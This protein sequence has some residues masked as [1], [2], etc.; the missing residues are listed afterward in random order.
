[1]LYVT[2][3]VPWPATTGGRVRTTQLLSRL[4]KHAKVRMVAITSAPGDGS[5]LNNPGHP[6]LEIRSFTNC[7]APGLINARYS[8]HA[9]RLIEAYIAA[10]EIDLIHLEGSYMSH[11]LPTNIDLPIVV[12]DQNVESAIIGQRVSIAQHSLPPRAVYRFRCREEKVWLSAFRVM[13]ASHEDA[14]LIRARIPQA[15]VVAI[16]NGWDHINTLARE[17]QTPPLRESV[18]S[19]PKLL[20]LANHNYL[21][22]KDGLRWL[23]DFIMPKVWR[24]QPNV[25]LI[26][27]GAESDHVL[28]GSMPHGPIE[29]KGWCVSVSKELDEADIVLCPLRLGGGVKVK[30]TEALQRH[31]PIVSTSVGVQGIPPSLHEAIYIADNATEFASHVCLL[32]SQPSERSRISRA[33]AQNLAKVPTWDWAAEAVLSIWRA[34][35]QT[36]RFN[37]IH[38]HR[39]AR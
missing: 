22:N 3:R 8:V 19:A 25:R 18:P 28:L 36:T 6:G 20:F 13:T 35:A 38:E 7:A 24:L 9:K 4:K 27:A 5:E 23:L 21:P 15:R 2:Y 1:M 26:L 12:S 29:I 37:A 30:I 10:D 16:P 11:L 31:R 33:M 14:A 39:I 32:S 17:Q 34:A